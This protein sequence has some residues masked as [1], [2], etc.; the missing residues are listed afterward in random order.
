MHSMEITERELQGM[1]EV[2]VT[3]GIWNFNGGYPKFKNV[4]CYFSTEFRINFARKKHAC[5]PSP[6]LLVKVGDPKKMTKGPPMP[7]S[8]KLK[9]SKS[10]KGSPLCL[11]SQT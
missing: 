5:K 3:S 4:L 9:F 10:N 6:R 8:S 11:T 2:H 1:L 7:N